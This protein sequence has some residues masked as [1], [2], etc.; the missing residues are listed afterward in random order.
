MAGSYL[1][2]V[3]FPLLIQEIGVWG[4][5]QFEV[6]KKYW[7]ILKLKPGGQTFIRLNVFSTITLHFCF[8][9]RL[10]TALHYIEKF[11]AFLKFNIWLKGRMNKICRCVLIYKFKSVSHCFFTEIYPPLLFFRAYYTAGRRIRKS[12]YDCFST[13]IPSIKNI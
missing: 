5:N 12:F 9:L 8:I 11:E 1:P 4:I 7:R 6:L 3:F 2:K 10:Y 13:Y